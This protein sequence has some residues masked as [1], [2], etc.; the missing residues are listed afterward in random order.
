MYR[1][2]VNIKVSWYHNYYIG[3]KRDGLI[4]LVGLFDSGGKCYPALSISRTFSSDLPDSFY[5]VDPDKL[6]N[7]IK[8]LFDSPLEREYV[9][10]LSY[11]NLGSIDYIERGYFLIDDIDSYE[12][13]RDPLSF[14]CCIAPVTYAELVKKGAIRIGRKEYTAQ[15]FA[16]YAYPDIRSKQYEAFLIYNTVEAYLFDHTNV[17]KNNIVIIDIAG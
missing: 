11:T 6:S 16:Y 1:K 10:C 5:Q 13:T 12:K 14:T 7:Q 8:S 17:D 4:Y 15:D 9:G 3:E 2:D